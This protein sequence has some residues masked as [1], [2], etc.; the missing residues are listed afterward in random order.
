MH[1][2]RAFRALLSE[3]KWYLVPKTGWVSGIKKSLK[4]SKANPEKSSKFFQKLKEDQGKVCSIVFIDASGFAHDY[5]RTRG[6]ALKRQ[7]CF[8]AHDW[9]RQGP[10]P[11]HRRTFGGVLLHLPSRES[12]FQTTVDTGV[13][14]PWVGCRAFFKNFLKTASLSWI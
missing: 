6:D 12:L 9:G 10:T 7:R 5:P 14:N 8:G 11:R 1:A 2:H 13:F 3:T 4:N